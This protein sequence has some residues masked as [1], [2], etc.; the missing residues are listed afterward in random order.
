MAKQGKKKS[1]LHLLSEAYP[2]YHR[3]QLRA[4]I[5]CRQVVVDGETCVDP[6]TLYPVESSVSIEI[7]RFVSRGGL[8]LEHALDSWGIDVHGL[9]MVDAGSSTGGFTDCL[10]Q[11]GATTVHAVDVGYNQLDYRLR[12]DTRVVVHERQNIMHI[13]ELK[14]QPQ[15]AVAD[16][17][18][19]SITGA[20]SH[21]LSLTRDKWLISLIKP[22]FEV[23]SDLKGFAGVVEHWQQIQEIL[24]LVYQQLETEGVG[25]KKIIESPIQGRK[26]NREFLALLEPGIYLHKQ[27]FSRI[28]D[29]LLNPLE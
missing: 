18:F 4:F 17:S 24:L 26:G 23:S 28:T 20:A 11:H 25:I 8:K 22:Q 14:P 7:P 10:L 21:I 3:T 6:K 15:G 2:Q 19:R 1:V 5:D 13:E 12:N 29:L 27:E 16:L 9:V